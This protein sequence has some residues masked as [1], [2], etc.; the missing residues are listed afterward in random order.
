[1]RVGGAFSEALVRTP[2]AA[3]DVHG[4]EAAA[5]EVAF[6]VSPRT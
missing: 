2:A 6:R 3:N 1:V 4:E 5:L